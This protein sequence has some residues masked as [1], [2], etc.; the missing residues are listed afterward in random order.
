MTPDVNLLV[1]AARDDHPH[2]RP[3][4]AWLQ[5]ALESCANGGTLEVLPMVAASVLRLLTNPRVFPV[6]M[7]TADALAFVDAIVAVPGVSMPELGRE[8]PVLRKLCATHRL[9]GNA[10]P[11]AWIAA[12]VI[13]HGLH[14]VSFDRDFRKLLPRAQFTLLSP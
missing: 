1:A 9:T 10:I 11:D 5:P 2:H 12:A 7:R 6:P 4:L 8:W 3:A 14:L 13:A